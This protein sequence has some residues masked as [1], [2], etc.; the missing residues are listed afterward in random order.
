MLICSVAEELDSSGQVEY[1]S[2][3]RVV[4]NILFSRLSRYIYFEI[5]E[6]ATFNFQ[7][8]V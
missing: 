4:I 7:C 2:H 8:V 1:I 5:D 6:L 3:R